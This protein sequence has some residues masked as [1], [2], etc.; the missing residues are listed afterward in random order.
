MSKHFFN[1]LLLTLLSLLCFTACSDEDNAASQAEVEEYT[2]AVV[3]PLNGET[4]EQWRNT[5]AWAVSN[6][7]KAQ[8]GC[9]RRVHLNIEMHDEDTEDISALG[10]ELSEREDV[11]AVVGPVNQQNL[12]MMAAALRFSGKPLMAISAGSTDVV[13]KYVEKNDFFWAMTQTDIS[14]CE[15]MIS[16]AA[17][18]GRRQFT[19]ICNGESI[20]S[21]TFKD[22]FPFQVT[23]LGLTVEGNYLYSKAQ[24]IPSLIEQGLCIEHGE[25]EAIICV[26]ADKEEATLMM[27]EID[28]R[29]RNVP[30]NERPT[31]YFSSNVVNMPIKE[32]NLCYDFFAV[33]PFVDPQSGFFTAYYAHTGTTPFTFEAQLYDAL[34]L[35]SMGLAHDAGN[36]KN[37]MKEVSG[38]EGAELRAWTSEA[39]SILFQEIEAGALQH[40]VMG[41]SS[42][43]LMDVDNHTCVTTSHFMLS[44]CQAGSFYPIAYYSPRGGGQTGS[45]LGDWNWQVTHI[46]DI[47]TT[48]KTF[49]YPDLHERWA[50][51]VAG[52][53]GFENYRHQ[54]DALNMY[55][56]LRASGYDD[57]HI[58]LVMADDIANDPQNTRPGEISITPDGVDV[59]KG[60]NIDYR[61]SELTAQQLL[62][63]M[64]A[65]PCDKD[66]NVLIFWSGHGSPRGLEYDRETC[67]PDMVKV[68]MDQMQGRY[69]KMMW[70]VEACYSGVVG[71]AIEGY[72]GVIAMTAAN[73]NE[74]SKAAVFNSEMNIW[75]SNRFTVYFIETL[76]VSPLTI[77]EMYYYLCVHTLG[78]HPS[79]YNS[80]NYDD[81]TTA[82]FKEYIP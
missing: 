71:Q 80:T 64:A 69:R 6:I 44:Y 15:V 53:T 75:M 77:R 33:Y 32:L 5:A 42:N 82:D 11:M 79:L 36:L 8:Q 13:R 10:K 26:P 27:K 18:T 28:K 35:L 81:I 24:E 63:K 25:K 62:D 70:L 72:P 21:Q 78:S 45:T 20:T 73:A 55:Q 68:L 39:M 52:S 23:E 56:Y 58:L 7:D 47:E 59:Y 2:V 4:A 40:H 16:T 19:L 41:A 38:N 1:L 3:V 74:T 67:T 48:T 17:Q 51:V 34:M 22:W 54:A 30:D 49:S 46:D 61:L 57:D 43:L 29:L 14:Q 12:G 37:A 50:V 66:D 76:K 31:I 60:A 9:K 65:L